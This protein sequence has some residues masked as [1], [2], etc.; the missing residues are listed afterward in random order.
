MITSILV[1][2]KLTPDEWAAIRKLAID[3]ATPVSV[4]VADVLREHLL[5]KG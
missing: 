4:L 3:R 5:R 1:R 2:T